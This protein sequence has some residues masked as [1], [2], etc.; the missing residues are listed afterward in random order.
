MSPAP[1]VG[2]L[3][4]I[5]VWAGIIV[6]VSLIAT[7]IKFKAPSLTLETGAEIGR[8][9]FRFWGRVELCFAAAAIA[10]AVMA[11]PLRITIVLL[12]V[13][14]IAT[15]LQRFWLWPILESR[16]TVRLA[17]GVPES[18]RHHNVY[19]AMEAVKAMLLIAAAV[20]ECCWRV[21]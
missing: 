18:S 12:V 21:G 5:A 1:A 13:V 10:L 3:I 19:A 17:G 7:P 14:L 16:V 20:A 8:Y 4:L 11:H 6:G 2:F 15:A 9:T